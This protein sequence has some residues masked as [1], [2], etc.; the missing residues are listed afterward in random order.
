MAAGQD[1]DRIEDERVKTAFALKTPV[2]PAP[3]LRRPESSRQAVRKLFNTRLGGLSPSDFHDGGV[4]V[5]TAVPMDVQNDE[6]Q[7]IVRVISSHHKTGTL[8]EEEAQILRDSVAMVI[9]SDIHDKEQMAQVTSLHDCLDSVRLKCQPVVLVHHSC[10]A[11]ASEDAEAAV[12]S[13]AVNDGINGFVLGQPEGFALACSIRSEIMREVLRVKK[14]TRSLQKNMRAVRHAEAIKLDMEQAIWGYFRYRLGCPIPTVDFDLGPC[15][16]GLPIGEFTVG[17]VLGGGACGTVW[18]L[19]CEDSPFSGHVLKAI[20]KVDSLNVLKTISNEIRIM[21]E[22]SS[23]EWHHPNIVKLY[24]VYHSDTHVMMQMEDGGSRNLHKVLRSYETKKL[25]LAMPRAKSIISQLLSAVSHMHLGPKIVHRDLKPENV[26]ARVSGDGDI[27]IK[28]CDFDLSRFA[29]NKSLS[30]TV[31]GT[32]PFMAPEMA[33]DQPFDMFAADIW[34]SG[35]VCLEVLCGVNVVPKAV[36][37]DRCEQ[38][39]DGFEQSVMNAAIGRYFEKPAAVNN[40]LEMRLRNELK[41]CMDASITALVKGLVTV[42][43]S[44]RW[45]AE[46]IVHV[47]DAQYS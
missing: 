19:D 15:Q 21:N 2:G 18:K 7:S 29:V 39:V 16:P 17:R 28:L 5:Y 4:V 44:Q 24:N 22:F 30:T 42:Q 34:S 37:N 41:D 9:F 35:I 38:P 36:F 46:E 23:G 6:F 33:T 13:Q 11:E 31:H 8:G 40:L 10:N 1:N 25:P 47:L 20:P 12:L 45:T 27:T 32:F 26:V 43:V 14:F 3:R